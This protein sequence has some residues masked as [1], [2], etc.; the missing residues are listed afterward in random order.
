MSQLT[1]TGDGLAVTLVLHITAS[2]HALAAGHAGAR[3]S[4]D[5]TILINV[6]LALDQSSGGV[7]TDGIE[8][9]VGINNFLLASDGVLNAEV[10]HQT[11]LLL[12]TENLGSDRVEADLD[13][14]VGQKT[15]GHGLGGTELVTTNKHGDA[16]AVLGQEHGLFGGRIT[17]TN[18]V[19]GLVAE[20]GNCT[21]AHSA[22]TDTVLP[23]DLLTRQVKAASIGTSGNDNS[24]GCASRL[25]VRTV[26]PLRPKLEGLL[27]QID[28]RDCLGDHFGSESD[29]LLAH[30]IHELRSVNAVRETG[31]VLDIGGR[32]K[33]TTCGGAVGQHTLIEDGLELRTRQIDRSGVSGGAR[34]DDCEWLVNPLSAT[35][36]A[37][38][39]RGTY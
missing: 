38:V 13:L 20:D 31:E 17:T 26:V 11:V 32:G 21:I 30:G 3:N 29:G 33:L 5:V 37:N 12:L 36:I 7:M 24:I 34:A 8:E 23:V 27:R 16:G 22:G 4:G 18:N 10:G 15:V 39:E 1:S 6:N 2:K 28:P 25:V 19:E 14:G 9:T 35:P